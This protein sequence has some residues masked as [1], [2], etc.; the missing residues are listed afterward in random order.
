[1]R[2][3][4]EYFRLTLVNE[5]LDESVDFREYLHKNS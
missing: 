5:N 4:I 3:C 1:M 2:I